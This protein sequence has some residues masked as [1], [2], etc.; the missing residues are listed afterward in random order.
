MLLL[1]PVGELVNHIRHLVFQV[2]WQWHINLSYVIPCH[3]I[4]NLPIPH[5]TLYVAP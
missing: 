5:I 4:L 3:G 2:L 1:R